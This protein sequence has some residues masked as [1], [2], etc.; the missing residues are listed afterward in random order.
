MPL[1]K[2][3]K[4]IREAR[5]AY[6]NDDPVMSDL[7]FDQLIAQLRQS[8]PNSVV[9]TEVGAKP[10]GVVI[11]HKEPMG[12]LSKVDDITD[13]R[14][15]LADDGPF[16][17]MDKLDGCS[18]SLEYKK[19]VLIRALTRGDGTKGEDI[20]ENVKLMQNVQKEIP[21]FTG[22]LRGEVLLDKQ[23][24]AKQYAE[25]YANP[26]NTAGGIMRRHSGE[27][28]EDLAIVFFRMSTAKG[29]PRISA[30]FREMAKKKVVC[31][32]WQEFD[33]IKQFIDN[34][35]TIDKG[36][37]AYKY[38]C[39][40]VV[41]AIEDLDKRDIGDPMRPSNQVAFKFAPDMVK[42]KV[43]D[44]VWEASRTGRV[45][46]VVKVEP[47]TVAGV[48]VSNVTGNN[49]PWLKNMGVG[50]GAQI[51]ISRRGDVIPAIEDVLKEGDKLKAPN[52]CLS[53]STVLKRVGAYL[54]CENNKCPE[55]AKGR[56]QHWLKL[57]DVKGAGP[58]AIE[59]IIYTYGI[60]QPVDLYWLTKKD[61]VN[62]LGKNGEKI[63]EEIQTKTDIPL[64][65]IFAGHVLNIGRR[66]FQMLMRAGFNTPSKLFKATVEQIKEVPGFSTIIAKRMVDGCK[67]YADS[68]KRLLI[69][70]E[71]KA[72]KKIKADAPLK[73][74]GFKFTGKMVM[75]RPD[76]EARAHD[77]G[78]EIGWSTGLI[79]VLVIADINSNSGKAKTARNKGY[80][81]WTPEK[82]LSKI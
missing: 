29:Y 24:F 55:K 40:G 76:M 7:A 42:T 64:E 11:K 23:T 65:V 66:R 78:A 3:E 6:Y 41:V 72:P 54:M 70:I 68:I 80:E 56:I 52:N 43:K 44:I 63:Y 5:I 30:M 46:P 57:I 27:G 13:L 36:R 39:D 60:A 32:R 45:N 12:S 75:K 10:R 31:V 71:I 58:A 79:N 16:I 26:R 28:S 17:L 73:G 19:G 33:S 35:E 81:L 59:S 2:T 18:C 25:D 1:T 38:E 47:V 77:A 67:E 14:K 15:W 22:T 34:F 51:V 62:E 20:T 74:Y 50:I 9:L 8:H 69:H 82:F 53:C 61:F 48:T 4:R 37:D 49:Y 21:G